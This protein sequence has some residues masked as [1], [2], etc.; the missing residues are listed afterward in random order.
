M[1]LL[2]AVQFA[3]GVMIIWKG[4]HPHITNTHV[5]TGALICATAALLTTRAGRLAHSRGW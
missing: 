4:R 2:I 1:L 3:L 5:V